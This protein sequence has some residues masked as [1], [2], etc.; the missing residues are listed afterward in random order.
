MSD[1]LAVHIIDG[2]TMVVPRQGIFQNGGPEDLVI[3][4]PSF[5]IRHPKGHVVF[6][7]G[8]QLDVAADPRGYWGPIADVFKVHMEPE[9]HVRAQVEALDVD[10]EEVRYVIVSHLHLDHTGSIG[11]FPNA[12]F[13]IHRKE[14]EYAHGPEWFSAAVYM[15]QDFD[16]PTKW[17][18]LDLDEAVPEYDLYGDGTIKI[19]FTPGHS[20]GHMSVVAGL[21]KEPLILAGDAID[22]QAHYDEEVMPGWYVDGSAVVRSL[23]RLKGHQERLGGALVIYGHDIEQWPSLKVGKASYA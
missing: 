2:G 3:P 17:T 5:L 6:E 12:E 20:H 22:A 19:V 18:Y 10:P 4:V 15:P 14:W 9:Q 13:L 8:N 7:G 11:H 1:D 16:R 23:A 21:Q